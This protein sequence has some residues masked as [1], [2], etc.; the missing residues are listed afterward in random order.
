MNMFLVAITNFLHNINPFERKKR[1]DNIADFFAE[2]NEKH[3]FKKEV[4]L[5]PKGYGECDDNYQWD[6]DEYSYYNEQTRA[7]R[8]KNNDEWFGTKKPSKKKTKPVKKNKRKGKN[9]R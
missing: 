7:K 5:E 8:I 1:Q 4:V 9:A 3:N 2:F 6:D